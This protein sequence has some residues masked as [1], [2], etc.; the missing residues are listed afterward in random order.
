ME[1]KEL[2]RKECYFKIKKLKTKGI[3]YPTLGNTFYVNS[4]TGNDICT[5]GKGTKH[6]FK[7]LNKALKSIDKN[8]NDVIILFGK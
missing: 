7:T 4:N 1:T 2:K 3:E 5:N 6:P 8:L